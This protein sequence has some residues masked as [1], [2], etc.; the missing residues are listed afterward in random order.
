MAE[1]N[2]TQ[3]MTA[4][5]WLHIKRMCG[6]FVPYCFFLLLLFITM[7]ILF[8]CFIVPIHSEKASLEKNERLYV[9]ESVEKYPYEMSLLKKDGLVTFSNKHNKKMNGYLYMQSDSSLPPSVKLQVKLQ[10]REIAISKKMATELGVSI[11]DTLSVDLDIPIKEYIVKE[12]LPYMSDFY[13]LEEKRDFSVGIMGKDSLLC[14]SVVCRFIYFFDEQN[15]ESTQQKISYKRKYVISSEKQSLDEE[16]FFKN[17]LWSTIMLFMS[18]IIFILGH[19][20]VCK[21]TEKYCYD[22]FSSAY[23]KRMEWAD[24]L[25]FLGIPVLLQL[26]WLCWQYYECLSVISKIIMFVMPLMLF[27]IVWRGGKK[28]GKA[29]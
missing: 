25:L 6:T 26:L 17:V 2:K 22:G 28:Y 10:E 18:V 27:I 1:E 5:Y 8:A 7:D 12:I 15:W 13:G 9:A 14:D 11:G 29:D 23:V 19:T 24:H 4:P 3:I 20:A 21:D 16:I